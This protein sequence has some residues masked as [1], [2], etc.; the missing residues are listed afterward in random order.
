VLAEFIETY[1]KRKRTLTTKGDDN[2]GPALKLGLMF[3][4]TGDRLRNLD[5]TQSDDKQLTR[6]ETRAQSF[7]TAFSRPLPS[8]GLPIRPAGSD[9]QKP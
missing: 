4:K 6:M 7:K 9:P 1:E 8:I 2:P 3:D 5:P